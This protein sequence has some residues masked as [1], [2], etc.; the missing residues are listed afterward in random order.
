MKIVYLKDDNGKLWVETITFTFLDAV[1]TLD[2]VR[3]REKRRQTSQN[4]NCKFC[5]TNIVVSF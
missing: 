1:A 4:P 2:V 3:A 5:M